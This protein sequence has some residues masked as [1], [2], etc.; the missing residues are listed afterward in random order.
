MRYVESLNNSLHKLMDQNDKIIVLGEDIIDPYG[1]AFKVTKGLS[2]KFPDR[3]I[4]TPIS[5]ASI[6][7]FSTGLAIAGFNPILEIMFGDF[8][9]LCTDQIINGSSKFHWMYGS[10]F[11][12][13]LVIRTPMG[14]RRG[15]GPTHS[16]TLESIFLGVPGIE[17]ISPSKFHNVGE[18]FSQTVL[19]AIKPTL[20]I[21]NKLLYP[22][23]LKLPDERNKIDD[24]F[25]SE[26]NNHNK[27]FPSIS[28]ILED[29]DEPDLTL[30]AY[31][32]MASIAV[33]SIFDYFIEE[34]VV[35]ELIIP[36]LIKPFPINDILPSLRKSG[37]A[38]IVEEGIKTSGWG[39]ELASQLNEA[40]FESL[41]AP[42]LRL[43]SKE[44]PIPGSKPLE[45]LILPQ[46]NDI[47]KT[48]D[49]ILQ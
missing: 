10:K 44:L 1:G 32:G 34:E 40:A 41:K 5:E 31:G 43:G 22:E 4:A 24:F 46:K 14:G 11:D 29:V 18:T 21:E 28:L 33:E 42:I 45:E 49:K 17:I 8:I 35:I 23:Q 27:R 47:L 16:Q 37:K 3:V 9:T 13:P 25:Y 38:I 26:I 12:V 7:G 36:S 6:T 19:N 39:A 48:I 20:F 15:Y 2:T 30:V